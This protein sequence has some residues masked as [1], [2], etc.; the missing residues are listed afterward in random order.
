MVDDIRQQN[1]RIG[2]VCL[3]LEYSP[4]LCQTIFQLTKGFCKCVGAA[5]RLKFSSNSFHGTKRKATHNNFR[6]MKLLNLPNAIIGMREASFDLLS[7]EPAVVSAA[8]GCGISVALAWNK[9][10]LFHA[11]GLKVAD[12]A[13]IFL[14]R[15]G[16]GKSTIVKHSSNSFC[17]H[18]DK[19]AVMKTRTGWIACSV[20]LLDNSGRP[21]NASFASLSGVY[22][23]EK[24]DKLF[25]HRLTP[26]EAFIKVAKLAY[27]PTADKELRKLVSEN[28]MELVTDVPIYCLGYLKGYDV[29]RLLD[30]S[31]HSFS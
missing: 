4:S 2:D 17:I 24:S 6:D 12:K 8:L 7:D 26:T 22:L 21:G 1:T 16:G 10:L 31:G 20:P 28:L 13:M 9:G 30:E 3:G 27:E 19:I 5:Y 15:S 11:A 29:S 14:A 25:L 23:V 18:D